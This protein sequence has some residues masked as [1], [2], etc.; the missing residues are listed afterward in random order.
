MPHIELAL[1]HGESGEPL[2]HA[3]GRA[4]PCRPVGVVIAK[5][6]AVAVASPLPGIELA[7]VDGERTN[8]F[9]RCSSIVV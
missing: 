3:G 5:D 1:V 4:T 8:E 6:S 2:P 9:D 7:I